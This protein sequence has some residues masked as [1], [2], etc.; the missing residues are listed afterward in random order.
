MPVPLSTLYG[1]GD[2][3]VDAVEDLLEA[4]N[5]N[6]L[7]VSKEMESLRYQNLL[8]SKKNVIYYVSCEMASFKH[9]A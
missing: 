3:R 8:P 7:E 2:T 5:G 9:R 4:H 1:R 6:T